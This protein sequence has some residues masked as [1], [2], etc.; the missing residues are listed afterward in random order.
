MKYLLWLAFRQLLPSPCEFRVHAPDT[1]VFLETHSLITSE[2][3]V[4]LPITHTWRCSCWQHVS[5]Y[6]HAV[7]AA[8]VRW[9]QGS[10]EHG[11]VV[12]GHPGPSR[13]PVSPRSGGGWDSLPAVWVWIIH[14]SRVKVG[15]LRTQLS[16]SSELKSMWGFPCGSAGKESACN[17]GDRSLIPWLGRSPGEGKG[18]S[19]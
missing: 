5:S 2:T 19:L 10:G 8:N 6:F 17:V 4:Q 16:V 3:E 18:Y 15:L 7:A 13:N 14:N 1:C 9:E 12:C 11:V